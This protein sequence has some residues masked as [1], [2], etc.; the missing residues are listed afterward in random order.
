MTTVIISFRDGIQLSSQIFGGCP[1]KKTLRNGPHKLPF[2][3]HF[4]PTNH[5]H[6]GEPSDPGSPQLGSTQSH[7]C[8][9]FGHLRS[10]PP[11]QVRKGEA[12]WG[13]TPN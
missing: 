8:D 10:S 3:F 13:E 9:Q 12:N 1:L 5:S 2:R 6:H 4:K 11:H 7:H